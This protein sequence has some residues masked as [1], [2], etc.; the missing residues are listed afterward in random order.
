MAHM[1]MP[2]SPSAEEDADEGFVGYPP[3]SRGIRPQPSPRQY[4]T[5]N[6]S[7]ER[8][9]DR[10]HYEMPRQANHEDVPYEGRYA[11]TQRAHDACMPQ[12]SCA[13]GKI[14]KTFRVKGVTD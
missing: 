3:L 13:F 2:D 8:L 10:D 1:E 14:C 12:P 11:A 5:P 4:V 6:R 7:G 9:S